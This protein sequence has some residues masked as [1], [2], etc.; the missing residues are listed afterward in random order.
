[1]CITTRCV[2]ILEKSNCNS[3]LENPS[4]SSLVCSDILKKVTSTNTFF[5]KR[6]KNLFF[7]LLLDNGFEGNFAWTKQFVKKM[8]KNL[9]FCSMFLENNLLET[10]HESQDHEPIYPGWIKNVRTVDF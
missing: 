6:L 9:G 1:M 7:F 3:N 4:A 5:Q 8:E 10:T 2:T